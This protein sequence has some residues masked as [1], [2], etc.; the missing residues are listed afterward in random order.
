[1]TRQEFLRV[2]AASGLFLA[3]P[4]AA[5]PSWSDRTADGVVR[6]RSDHSFP[7]TVARIK[8]AL[9]ANEIRFFGEID[10]GAL[11]SGAGL[12]LGPST[13]LLFGNPPLG[14][15]LLTANPFAGLD[16]PVR[17]LV[18]EEKPGQVW[19]AWTDFAWI[20]RRYGMQGREAVIAKATAVAAMIAGSA[21]Q[22]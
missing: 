13:L 19:I 16:W 2:A 17:R 20:A 14:L 1:M 8:A 11:A 9:A 7:D 4:A 21:R 10:Q 5:A 22:G 6:V 18:T 3:A 12:E 15:Q